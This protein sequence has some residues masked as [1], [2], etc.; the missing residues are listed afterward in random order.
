V[1][2]ESGE[3]GGPG[4]SV[5]LR[6]TDGAPPVRLGEGRA[7]TLS[8]DGR[9]VLSIP[10]AGSP[11]ILALPTGAG[12]A[13]VLGEGLEGHAVAHWFPDS[14]RVV[15]G[16]SER[17]RPLRFWQQD[18]EGGPAR[19]VTP[20]NMAPWRPRVSPDAELLLARA[21]GID[22]RWHFYPLG[23]GA[24]RPVPGLRPEDGVLAWSSDGRTLYVGVGRPTPTVER[25]DIATGAREKWREVRPSDSSGTSKILNLFLTRDARYL[26]Y[27]LERSFSELYLVDGLH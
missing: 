9:W 1:I 5:F 18:L 17:G 19:A 3:G 24:P 20:E 6:P 21:A 11:R 7:Q 16:A 27:T 15:F 4:Y 25:L 13:R 22:G 26:A 23:G 2:S 10:V 14:R 12:D 8:P